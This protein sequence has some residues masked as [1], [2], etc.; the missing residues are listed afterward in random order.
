MKL[1]VTKGSG[2]PT[3]PMADLWRAVCNPSVAMILAATERM[4][5]DWMKG[6]APR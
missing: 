4:L 5:F 2:E 3:A 1:T 6:A